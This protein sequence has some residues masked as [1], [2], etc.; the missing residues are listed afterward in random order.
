MRNIWLAGSMPLS[1][2]F[3]EVI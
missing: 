2:M 1:G 3:L